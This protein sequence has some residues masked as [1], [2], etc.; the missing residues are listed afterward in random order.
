MKTI[1]SILLVI[2]ICSSSQAQNKDS[3]WTSPASRAEVS[4][5]TIASDGTL[6][7]A[8]DDVIPDG[9]GASDVYTQ[10]SGIDPQTGSVK[11]KFPVVPSRSSQRFS[12]LNFIT[13]T[14]FFELP[15]GPLTIIDPYDG[16]VIVDL[17]K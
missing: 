7:T 12:E 4:W 10:L 8:V 9:T 6:I 13:N 5:L 17:A 16:H 3:L 2:T 14:P 1:L 11:W 15:K